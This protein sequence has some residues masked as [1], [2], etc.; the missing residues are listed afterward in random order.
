MIVRKE[1]FETSLS[2]NSITLYPFVSVQKYSVN[3]H[4]EHPVLSDFM[5]TSCGP[6]LKN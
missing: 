1:I 2:L 6:C 5:F 4:L 3:I